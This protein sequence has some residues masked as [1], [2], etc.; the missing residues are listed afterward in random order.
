VVDII[1]GVEG[2]LINIYPNP[3]QDVLSMDMNLSQN[4]KI[5]IK[6]VDMQGR[7]IKTITS[8]RKNGAKT[9]KT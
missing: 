3:I 6:L 7:L 4:A 9:F 5:Q 2:N 8:Q 1:W